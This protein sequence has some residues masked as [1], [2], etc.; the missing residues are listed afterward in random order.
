MKSKDKIR[1]ETTRLI[2][3]ALQYEEM[4]KKVDSLPEA[5]AVAV[6]Q[7]EI[8][9]R[10]EEIEFAEKAGREE[11]KQKLLQEIAVIEEFLPKQLSPGELEKIISDFKEQNPSANM[12][13]AMKDLK[14]NFAGKYDGSLASQI[15]KR[16]FA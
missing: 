16:I 5:A 8:G 4:Q 3:S 6:L 12:G 11:L 10:K 13:L 1:L 9:R 15:A 7:R 14:D 2:L